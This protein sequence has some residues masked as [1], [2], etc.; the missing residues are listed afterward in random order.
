MNKPWAYIYSKNIFGGFISGE[1]WNLL[2]EGVLRFKMG[3]FRRWGGAE[4]GWLGFIRL[5]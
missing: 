3:S 4:N 5:K 2:L 1:D